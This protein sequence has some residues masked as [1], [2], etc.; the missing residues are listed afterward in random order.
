MRDLLDRL[1][2]IL[3]SQNNNFPQV[4][5]CFDISVSSDFNIESTVVE[6]A[7]DF[8]VIELDE[9]AMQYLKQNGVVLIEKKHGNSKI[10]DQ[11]W[12]GYK[13]VS[14]K[15]RGEKG[16]CE[17]ISEAKYQGRSVTLNKPTKGDV[18]KSK[19]YVRDPKTGNVKKINFGDPNMKIKKSN[20]ARRKSFRARH[21]CSTAKD[22]TT[23]RYWSCRSW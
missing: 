17:K 18:K 10:Y 19:V 13:K 14:G 21:K 23:A 3:Y 6:S 20:P 4:G 9:T 7:D 22:K 16:S 2:A 8:I 15:Q 11:C 5:D 1:D 12:K